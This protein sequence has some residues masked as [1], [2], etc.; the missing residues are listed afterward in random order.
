M[1]DDV[2]D[3]ETY[4]SD[5]TPSDAD[6]ATFLGNIVLDNIMTAVIALSSEVWANRRRMKIIESLLA[7]N[8]SVTAE[9]IERYMPTPEEE[10][11]WEAER[12]RF[13]AG[14]FSALTRGG[15][16]LTLSSSRQD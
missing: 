3:R 10:A 2:Q 9:M 11:S 16:D 15:G 13:I 1:A 12:D 7:Q 6:R 4:A 8:G 5:F 14:T